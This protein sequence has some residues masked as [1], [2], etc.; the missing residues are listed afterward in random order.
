[1]GVCGCLRAT[2]WKQSV[3]GVT[4]KS[5]TWIKHLSSFVTDMDTKTG[6]RQEMEFPGIF[7]KGFYMRKIKVTW[8]GFRKPIM[9]VSR[10]MLK[11]LCQSGPRLC[12][13]ISKMALIF[14]WVCTHPG[15][16]GCPMAAVPNL[17][18]TETAFMEDT[19]LH[20]LRGGGWF[21]DETITFIVRFISSLMPPWMWQQVLV[22]GLEVGD[23]CPRV[24]LGLCLILVWFAVVRDVKVSW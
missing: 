14:R 11:R 23:P 18:G 24:R 8:G 5:I 2:G 17:F 19:F 15:H 4:D 12:V 20:G 16:V 7:G 6:A 9:V 1:M 3:C 21:Q 10:E 22:C 13:Q